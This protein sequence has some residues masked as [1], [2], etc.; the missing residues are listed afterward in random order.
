MHLD[1][2]KGGGKDLGAGDVVDEGAA[3]RHVVSGAGAAWTPGAPPLI[4]TGASRGGGGS[5]IVY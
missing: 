3:Q 2:R 1:L 5:W 4:L